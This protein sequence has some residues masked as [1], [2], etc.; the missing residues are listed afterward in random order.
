MR[1]REKQPSVFV[2][3]R[4]REKIVKSVSSI[5]FQITAFL[6]FLDASVLVFALKQPYWSGPRM[7]KVIDYNGTSFVHG[8]LVVET[9][10]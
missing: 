9:N 4:M 1:L 7:P 10:C 6:R 8:Q 2:R 3:I 5:I